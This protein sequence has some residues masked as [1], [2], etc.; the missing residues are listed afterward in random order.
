MEQ[1]SIP[2]TGWPEVIHEFMVKELIISIKEL[3]FERKNEIVD[4][5][6]RHHLKVR[7]VP[8][9][10]SWVRGELDVK[11]IKEVNIED[12]LGR[13]V[14]KLD[15]DKLK[16]QIHRRVVLITGGAGSIGS[17]LARQVILFEP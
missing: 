6:L 10:E 11:Q 8:P 5:A 3:S 16:E 14:I 13:E 2:A 9:A 12:L 17:E 4:E 15:H 7:N 1:R